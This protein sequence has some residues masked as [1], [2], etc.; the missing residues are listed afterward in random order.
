MISPTVHARVERGVGRPGDDLHVPAHGPQGATDHRGDVLAFEKDLAGRGL[1]QLDD[2][3]TAV[4][5]RSRT[6]PRAPESRLQRS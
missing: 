5:C 3:P 6:R 2:E 4:V 1:D